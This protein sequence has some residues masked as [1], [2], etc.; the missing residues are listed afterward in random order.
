MIAVEPCEVEV[1]E[2]VAQEDQTAELT[3][4]E[5]RNGISSPADI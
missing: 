2:D 5:Q 4:L 1:G 3:G